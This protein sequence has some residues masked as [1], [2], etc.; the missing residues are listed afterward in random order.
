M[1]KNTK[2]LLPQTPPSWY[3]SNHTFQHLFLIFTE[4]KD[5]LIGEN[6]SNNNNKNNKIK[7]KII[8]LF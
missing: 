4:A 5:A 6:I 3:R 8:P 1:K 7:I 2:S